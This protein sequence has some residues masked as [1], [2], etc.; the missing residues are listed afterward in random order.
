MHDH[1]QEVD[2]GVADGLWRVE[3]VGLKGEA[4]AEVGGDDARGRVE[5]ARDDLGQVLYDDLQGRVGERDG[6]GAVAYVAGDVD[7]DA[8]GGEF[9]PGE[10]ACCVRV[11]HDGEGAH[12]GHELG[13]TLAHPGLSLALVVRVHGQV[14]LAGK[15]Q[16]GFVGVW[17]AVAEVFEGPD[18]LDGH[19]EHVARDVGVEGRD[20]RVRHQ[21]LGRGRVGDVVRGRFVEDVDLD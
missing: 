7:H 17:A 20:A 11:G 13:E 9:V 2:G 6:D 21:E 3:V 8:V 4:G 16:P 1:A 19:G 12:V 10:P 18:L 15:V 14:G 5:G